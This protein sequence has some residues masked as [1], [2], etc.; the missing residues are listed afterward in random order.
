M[1]VPP[2]E[3]R[4]GFEHEVDLWATKV[5][6]VSAR[7]PFEVKPGYDPD[8]IFATLAKG[9]PAPAI[10]RPLAADFLKL[11]I[12]TEPERALFTDA[13]AKLGADADQWAYTESA[14]GI[15]DS[16]LLVTRFDPSQPEATRRVLL[17]IDGQPPT[18]AEAQQWRDDG[19]DTTKPLGELPPLARV[20][21]LKDLRVFHEDATAVVF[22]APL[23][24]DS[25]DFPAE[26]FQALF[27][28]N[29]AQ[30]GLE[31]ITVKL[32][33][34]FRVAGV[35]KVTDAGLE[36]QLQRL[37]PA[38]APQPVKLKAGGGVRVLL[39]KFARTFEAT[40]TDFKRVVPWDDPVPEK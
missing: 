10:V 27:R 1:E 19:G 21:D 26:K 18:P 3:A 30:R 40:R 2:D 17:S 16:R 9:R 22:E 34:S 23:R 15:E 14:R 11:R 36:L 7:W 12:A 32:R 35:V 31:E 39:V 24:A 38:L 37:D 33:E 20:V 29:R 4:V 5:G 8:A 6:K 13:Y 25:A 28:V